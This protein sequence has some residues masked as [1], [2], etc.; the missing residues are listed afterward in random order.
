MSGRKYSTGLFYTYVAI[1]NMFIQRTW[2]DT[3]VVVA[4]ANGKEEEEE[5]LNI[6]RQFIWEAVDGAFFLLMYLYT[7]NRPCLYKPLSLSPYFY[8]YI[9]T[10]EL[11]TNGLTAY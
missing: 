8:I 9:H 1:S 10:A 4:R 7:S 11:K 5:D 2:V 3:Y 6:K